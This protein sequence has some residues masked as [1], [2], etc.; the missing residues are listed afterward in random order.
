MERRIG[1]DSS[2]FL[3]LN[4]AHLTPRDGGIIAANL[5]T[6]VLRDFA[7]T[8]AAAILVSPHRRRTMA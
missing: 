4:L 8:D 6:M 2:T 5:K 3:Q 7:G 1:E